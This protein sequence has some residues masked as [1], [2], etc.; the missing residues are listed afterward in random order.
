MSS[1]PSLGAI[2][3]WGSCGP[4]EDWEVEGVGVR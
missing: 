3:V 2:F 1:S 4:E